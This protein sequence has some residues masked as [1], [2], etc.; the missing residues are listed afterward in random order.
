MSKGTA[1]VDPAIIVT[2]PE[3]LLVRRAADEAVERLTRQFPDRG[4]RLLDCSRRSESMLAP[5]IH[6][7]RLRIALSPVKAPPR[8]PS[9]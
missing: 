7:I 8:V 4:V 1:R 6:S 5:S 9:R 2:G 3:P